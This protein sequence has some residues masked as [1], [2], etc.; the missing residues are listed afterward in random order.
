MSLKLPSKTGLPLFKE[1]YTFSSGLEESIIRNIQALSQLA[2]IVRTSYG[3]QGRNKIVINHLDRT[4]VTN[5]AS[6]ILRELEVVHPAAKMATSN[7]EAMGEEIGDRSNLV[8]MLCGELLK[9]SESL[10]LMGLH[11]SEIVEGW[12]VAGQKCLQEL[13]SLAVQTLPIPPT[14]ES[15]TTLLRTVLGS[16][17]Y[18]NEDYVS[19][20]V[21]EAVLQVLPNDLTKF[22]PDSIRV[23]KIM[24]GSL[25]Q[26]KVVKGMVFPREPEGS[27]KRVTNAKVGVF[28]SGVDIATTETKGTVLLK[29]SE[30]LLGFSKGEE[31]QLEKTIKELADS[32]MKVL[33]AGSTVGDLALHYLSKYSILLLRIPS[34]FDLQRLCRVVGATPLARL[35]APTAEEMGYV[36]VV[37]AIEIGGDRVTVFR[38]EEGSDSRTST[39]LLRGNTTSYLDALDRSIGSS[40]HVVKAMLRDSRLVPGAGATE[41][42]LSKRVAEF[43]EKTAGMK[44][45][46]IKRFADALEVV[47]RTLVENAGG[48][49]AEGSE[50]MGRLYARHQQAGGEA[51]GV[52]VEGEGDGTLD[53]KKAGIYDLLVGTQWGIK[54]AVDAATSILRVD[55]IIMSKP[56]GLKAPKQNPNWDED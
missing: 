15:I 10:L 46:A 51:I 18:G 29:N 33:V 12:E 21:A 28:T 45:H 22:T 27:I 9:K 49:G 56:A 3:P 52:D 36:S 44:Q 26:S 32:G 47:P 30:E 39:I 55:G 38:Q 41:L 50:V 54:L 19:S 8:L 43:G 40:L 20:L 4:F 6:T 11:P 5:E 1:G 53:T 48:G 31:E 34:K 35:G 7:V 16:K 23:V 14:T 17:H 37:E 13:D 24:G 2:E 25:S 42:E